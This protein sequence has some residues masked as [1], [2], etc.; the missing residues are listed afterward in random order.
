MKNIV[1][2]IFGAGLVLAAISCKR[3]NQELVGQLEQE[4]TTIKGTMPG[5]D[6][7]S[8][9]TAALVKQ[10]E[11]VPAGF[12]AHP[13]YQFADMYMKAVAINERMNLVKAM[14]QE[15]TEKLDSVMREYSAGTIT[16]DSVKTIIKSTSDA[17]A[18][19]PKMT[20]QME[21]FINEVSAQFNQSLEA[22]N[23]LP[24]A[25]RRKAEQGPTI[26]K[27]LLRSAPPE[28]GPSTSPK[29]GN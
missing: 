6:S 25:E 16:E 22:W 21:P 29:Q 24:E 10:M 27:G 19:I 9:K 12:K 2:A 13:Q 7:F 17:F 18:G 1:L 8:Q 23:A 11:T 28:V 14:G 15:F 26:I 4:L 5:L 20:S 3:V